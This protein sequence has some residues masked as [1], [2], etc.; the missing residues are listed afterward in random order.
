MMH[1]NFFKNTARSNGFTLLELLLVVGVTA[2][3]FAGIAALSRSWLESEIA[4]GAGQHMQRV[5]RIVEDHIK[6]NWGT[7]PATNNALTD[8]NPGWAALR[9]TLQQENLFDGTRIR[10]PLG[11][12]LRISYVR[13][14]VAPNE[15]FRATIYTVNNIAS[16][17]ALNAARQAGGTGGVIAN[18]PN[19]NNAIGAY[20]QYQV[21][22][23]NLA[24]TPPLA[25]VASATRSCLVA[26]VAV[27]SAV[28][29]GSFLYRE[30]MGNNALNTM[31]TDLIMNNNN[32]LG[33][34]DINANNLNIANDANL[35][36]TTVA[37]N[38]TL[39]GPATMTNGMTVN[40]GMDVTGNA[41]FANNVIM[42]D[43]VL[44]A[45]TI[46]STR[47]Q[48]PTI[49]ANTFNTQDLTV[50]GN[51]NVAIEG[52]VNVQGNVNTTGQVLATE[53]NAGSIQTNNGAIRTGSI[54][55]SN[56]MTINGDVTFADPN[57]RVMVVDRLVSDDCVRIPDNLDPTITKNYG[58][59]P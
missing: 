4:A 49:T 5:S 56:T 20:G 6:A 25:C 40:G 3:M 42:N 8:A 14:G 18:F 48:A 13:Q 21:A 47:I 12:D 31:S 35:G 26:V 44:S 33:A 1:K 43:G 11:V 16:S 58:I 15:I 7:L 10:S 39:N 17:R 30:D 2:L 46:N 52:T 50:T 27:N 54:D 38:T 34:N 37:G 53:L 29:N 36:T 45:D 51:G 22:V 41:S 23:A 9:Q 24:P 59:C 57:N 55:V 28:M 32:I 19:P